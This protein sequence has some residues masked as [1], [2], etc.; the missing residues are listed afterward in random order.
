M[1]AL[2][3]RLGCASPI[4]QQQLQSVGAVALIRAL[5]AS[6][7]PAEQHDERKATPGRCPGPALY[8]GVH[9]QESTWSFSWDALPLPTRMRTMGRAGMLCSP[10]QGCAA[11]VVIQEAEPRLD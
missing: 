10:K 8:T 2:L 3:Q 7:Q 11:R 1:L 5:F 4:G 9:V 6:A